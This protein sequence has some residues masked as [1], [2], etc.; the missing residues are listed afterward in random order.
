LKTDDS[1]SKEPLQISKSQINQDKATT[2]TSAPV[3]N[4]SYRGIKRNRTCFK[5]LQEEYSRMGSNYSREFVQLT[6]DKY[7]FTFKQVY[8]FFWDIREKERREKV[9]G[10]VIF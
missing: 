9:N 10:G 3:H 8:K 2:S 5:I 7:G 4:W 6:A 1:E